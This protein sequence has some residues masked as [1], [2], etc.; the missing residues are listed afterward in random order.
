MSG[1]M[2]MTKTVTLGRRF[3]LV[4]LATALLA[5]AGAAEASVAF[6]SGFASTPLA[7]ANP[8]A[9]SWSSGSLAVTPG[10]GTNRVLVVAVTMALGSTGTFSASATYNGATATQGT[11]TS[12]STTRGVWIGYFKEASLPATGSANLT[13]AVTSSQSFNGVS[14]FAATFSGVNQTTALSGSGQTS[15]N[16]I[17]LTLPSALTSNAGGAF[18]AVVSRATGRTDTLGPATWT[19]TA[20]STNVGS[21]VGTKLTASATTEATTST[22]DTAS[23]Q[24][25]GAVALNPAA[26]GTVNLANGT[27]P[28]NSV[29]LG[30]SAAADA[31]TLATTSGSATVSGITVTLTNPAALSSLFLYGNASCTGGTQVGTAA[32]AAAT[33]SFTGLTLGV[34]TTPTPL[35]VCGQGASV[36]AATA[37]TAVASSATTSTAGYTVGASADVAGTLT[38]NP[39][40]VPGTTTGTVAA[41]V[42]SCAQVAVSASY[43]GD[44]DGDNTVTF[45]RSTDGTAFTTLAG[46]TNVGG[47]A[48]PRACTDAT[49]AAG[50]RYWYRAQFSDATGGIVG[51]NP[52]TTA[53]SVDT[54]VC[55]SSLVLS[56]PGGQPAPGTLAVGAAA[57][58]PVGRL[59][60]AAS[61]GTL[62]LDALAISNGAGAPRATGADLQLNLLN[63]SGTAVDATG[64]WDGTKWVFGSIVDGTTGLPVVL[65]TTPVTFQVYATA[66][67]GATAGETFAMSIA[68]ADVLG[69]APASAT[70][71][72]AFTASPF[73]TA[74]P[75]VVVAGSLT[76]TASAMVSVLDP[77]KGKVVSSPFLV[78]LY[79]CSAN[80]SALAALGLTTDGSTPSCSVN[81][82]AFTKD[83]HVYPSA[84][85]A[86]WARSVSL[87]VGTY[88]LKACAR[89]GTGSAIVSEPVTITVRAAGV[90]DGNLLVRDDSSQLCTDCHDQGKIKPHTSESTG[91]RY[92]TWATTCRDCHTPHDTRNLFL[93][94]EQIVPPTVNGYQPSRNV[95]LAN[96]TGDSNVSGAASPAG[97]SFVNT[98]ASGACQVCHTRTMN[99]SRAYRSG[100]FTNGSTTVTAGASVF[101]AGAAPAGDVGNQLLAPDGRSYAIATVASG[102]SATLATAYQGA[103]VSGTGAFRV[104][105]ARWR[106][107]GNGDS[108][109]T[110]AAGTSSCTGCHSHG[111]GFGAGES[112]GGAKCSSCHGTI[113]DS[114]TGATASRHALGNVVGT[115]DAPTDS[116]PS[117]GTQ[118]AL[119]NVPAAQRSCVNMCHDDHVHDA[120]PGTTH[121]QDVYTDARS[122][123]SRAMTRDASGNVTAGTPARTDFS[124][125]ATT[126]AWGGMCT[127]CH[128]TPVDA[129]RPAVP[130]AAYAGGGHD[131]TTTSDGTNTFT[132]GYTLHDGSRFDRNCTKC[133]ASRAEGTTPTAGASGSG[134]AAVHGTPDP[135]LLAGGTSLQNA[136]AAPFVCWNCHGSAANPA[137]GAQGNRSRKNLQAVFAKA[138]AHPLATTD[139]PHATAAE[140]AGATFGAGL[141]AGVVRHAACADCHDPHQA[142]AGLH[143]AGGNK[144]G[145]SLQGAWGAQLSSNPAFWTAPASANFTKKTIA[146]GTDLEATLCFKCHS[147][148]Y[149]TLP[150]SPSGGF[151]ETDT[152][153]EFNPANV[154]NFATTGTTSWQAGETAGSYHPVLATAGSNL[155]AINLTNLVTTNV[156]WSTTARNLMT[157]SDCHASDTSTDPGGPHG[158]AAKFVLRGPNTKWDSTII[159]ATTAP[160][161][162]FCLNCH[163]ATFTGSR[164]PGH[165]NGN[166][167]GRVPC[168]N[169]HAA[170]PHGGPR[171]GMLNPAAGTNATNL[172]AIAGWDGAAP[173]WGGTTTNRLYLVSYPAT[174]TT[175][176]AQSNCGCNGTGH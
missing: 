125:N 176:W 128:Q 151:V 28:A 10:A 145:P 27:D 34:S 31:F 71:G 29:T 107:S 134:T 53:S 30:Q 103:T 149:G 113:W 66:S 76:D 95:Y 37:V 132:W 57:W 59:A 156:A 47:G 111:A 55:A 155:G 41:T 72:V 114:M 116:G 100:T 104:G 163:S 6:V 18:V 169:C 162:T 168:L 137:S 131:G 158:S 96:T 148:W 74:A 56:N 23:V 102:T 91:S 33:V 98:D 88:T 150:A 157:C 94:R 4:A 36:G 123:A 62:T 14:V 22:L 49:V 147:S 67:Y 80:G 19:T 167:T 108:H 1:S 106:G 160:A 173:Y 138:S 70:T 21:N 165:T 92:G 9:V 153:K 32:P 109:F 143:A 130:A 5:W 121:E 85:A 99:P 83:A 140:L 43:T 166:H 127:S 170:I 60:L 75:A 40:P 65:G 87:P 24:A 82:P 119:A 174:P 141:G 142:K 115:N 105:P 2:S 51:A 16:A 50:T 175:S 25:L 46:C 77:E 35:W 117:W 120:S 89:N 84:S 152:A 86:T 44:T 81:D 118:T 12:A 69:L 17:T 42:V 139:A 171:M 68:P 93:I 144:A 13:V 64:R 15:G 110:A 61:S 38:V 45:S 20:N 52:I 8:A 133:H 54:G 97:S 159:L 112:A 63:A 161:G 3:A 101:V 7:T 135:S 79:V 122:A 136:A 126:Q 11:V 146:A 164:F 48:N 124:Y 73:T 154:G 26:G 78:Q 58:T 129:S 90:G 39:P 172:P